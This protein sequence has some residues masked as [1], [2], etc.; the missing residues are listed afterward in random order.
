MPLFTK[1]GV[2]LDSVQFNTDPNPYE[3]LNWKKRISKHPTIG[4]RQVIQD[5]G[6]YM[7]DNVLRLGSGDKQV[8]DSVKVI[9]LHTRYRT[10]GAVYSFSDYL[11]NVFSVVI[12]DFVPIIFR[13]GVDQAGVVTDLYRYTMELQTV[14]ITT[15]FGQPYT[16]G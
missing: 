7:V 14:T 12:M 6:V 4:D 8:L 13:R 5:F 11:G 10:R 3:N 9:A 2:F 16:G 1:G 15:L